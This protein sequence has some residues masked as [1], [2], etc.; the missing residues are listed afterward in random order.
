MK[1]KD[2]I[3]PNNSKLAHLFKNHYINIVEN[4]SGMPPKNIGNLECKSGNHLTVEKIIKYYKNHSSIE[5]INKI[6]TKKENFDIHTATTVEI[7]KIM[8]ES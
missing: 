3:V 7:S 8:R 6:C 1:D 2:K 4:T 5:T